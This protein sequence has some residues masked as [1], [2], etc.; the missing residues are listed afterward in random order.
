MTLPTPLTGPAYR[1][2]TQRLV[3]RC[4]NP[5]D[6]YLLKEAIEASIEHL[7]P[8]MP[9][10][11][12]EPLELQ[13]RIDLLRTWRSDFDSD[14]NYTYG[15]FD[16]DESRV[17]GG[18][19]LH[20]RVG[21]GGIEIGYWI[22]AGE[23]NQGLASETAAALTQ[24]AFELLDLERVE[25][26]CDERN[27]C[28]AAVPRKLGYALDGTLRQRKLRPGDDPANTMIWSLLRPEY[29]QSALKLTPVEAYDAL[30]RRML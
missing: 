13:A 15:I 20:P 3:L 1:I 9:W 28:S 23:I 29:E 4:W 16:R 11:Q 14:R 10:I 22:H 26:H 18:T 7:R 24:V 19:G 27:L 2:Q 8:W 6:V 30:G 21:P 25:I 17:L 5:A 12:N